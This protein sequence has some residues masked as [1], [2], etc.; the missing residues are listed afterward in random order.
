MILLLHISSYPSLNMFA[1]KTLTFQ[2]FEEIM[3]NLK[4]SDDVYELFEKASGFED[5]RELAWAYR[6]GT[7]VDVLHSNPEDDYSTLIR[8]Q[9]IV[10]G[11]CP[12]EHDAKFLIM[13]IET[14]DVT[15]DNVAFM[16]L[17]STK[18]DIVTIMH[19]LP[20]PGRWYLWFHYIAI[21]DW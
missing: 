14:G 2:E 21:P 5:F 19:N 18:C 10:V 11:S 3:N 17:P 16:E 4:T 15:S 9:A 8:K 20:M 6:P 12:D 13:N 1:N 7:I